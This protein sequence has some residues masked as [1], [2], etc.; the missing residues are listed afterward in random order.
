[1]VPYGR[2]SISEEDIQAVVDVLRSDWLTQGP[3][4]DIFER[5]VASYCGAAAAVALNSA[6]SALHAAC[7][8][9]DIGPGDVVWT[10]P[11]SFVASAN[12]ALMCGADVDFVDIDPSTGNL[13]VD[14]LEEKLRRA[15]TSRRLPAALI[16]V[17]FAGQPC[18]M[19][20]IW[21]LA[22]RYGFR[23]IE[24]A[25]HAIG[26]EYRGDRVGSGRYADISVFSF[27]PVKIITTGEGGVAL[28]KDS[29]LA[30]RIKRLRSHGVTRDPGLF[31]GDG[32][33][34][35]Y[36]QQLELGFNYRM[37][38]IQAAL[39]TS[40]LARLDGFVAR[41]NELALRYRELLDG[42]P[43]RHLLQRDDRL[44][45]YH[46]YVVRLD[47]GALRRQVY[48]CLQA[49]GIKVNVHYIPIHLQP[50]YRKRGFMPGDFPAAEEYYGRALTLPLYP[51]LTNAEQ[52]AVADALRDALR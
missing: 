50:Y 10:S 32:D 13:S 33:G 51:G 41:R 11:N 18:D 16:P 31:Q 8:A 14:A 9:L 1:M 4:V 38:D 46:L 37:T 48:D 6:T 39:G 17:H 25:S 47:D 35:W 24:D 45:A 36:Y 3:A 15:E 23:V 2:Q 52:A 34:G 26:A 49:R 42:L 43:L 22:D 19:A 21:A 12:C 29:V 40:Q 20:E 28:A 30:E 5:S 7:L 27:H 44:S